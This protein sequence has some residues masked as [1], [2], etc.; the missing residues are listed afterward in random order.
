MYILKSERTKQGITQKELAKRLKITQ[1]HL[2]RIENGKS[3]P[4]LDLMKKIAK[5]L[6]SSVQELFFS[7][8]E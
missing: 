5:E 8:E 1:Q 3:I 7:D 6:N 4:R 2:C